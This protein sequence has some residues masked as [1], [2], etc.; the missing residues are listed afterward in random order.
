MRHAGVDQHIILVEEL[1]S[2]QGGDFDVDEDDPELVLVVAW[3]A[4]PGRKKVTSVML[5]FTAV[6]SLS[7]LNA[8]KSLGN[9]N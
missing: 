4:V 9:P 5:L 7:A 8:W 2:R 3:I 6:N 1:D